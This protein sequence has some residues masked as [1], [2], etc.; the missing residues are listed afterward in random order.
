MAKTIKC[1]KCGADAKAWGR[2]LCWCDKDF[3]NGQRCGADDL[4][5]EFEC[6]ACGEKGTTPEAKSYRAMYAPKD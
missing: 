2:V 4:A 3:C 6:E 5:E 1:P